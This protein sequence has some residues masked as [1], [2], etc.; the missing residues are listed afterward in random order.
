MTQA[1][2]E[3]L[4]ATLPAA[5][6]LSL[7]QAAGRMLGALNPTGLILPMPWQDDTVL[8]PALEVEPD[9]DD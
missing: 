2:S 4:Y 5:G 7:A 1:R 3:P 9:P 8:R 6:A